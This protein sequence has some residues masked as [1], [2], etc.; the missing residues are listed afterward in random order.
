MAPFGV[1]KRSMIEVAREVVAIVDHTKWGHTAFATFC[2]TEELTS[3]I[4]DRSAPETM[5]TAPEG[6]G[7]EISLVPYA[8]DPAADGVP[9]RSS[10]VDRDPGDMPTSTSSLLG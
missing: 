4:S 7:I 5:V 6:R 1:I 10:R 3:V 9:I 8:T 2:R